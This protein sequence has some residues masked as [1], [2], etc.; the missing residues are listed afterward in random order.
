MKLKIV[1]FDAIEVRVVFGGSGG[2]A[3]F[4]VNFIIGEV[5]LLSLW[6]HGEPRAGPMLR[7]SL[8][9][10]AVCEAWYIIVARP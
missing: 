7:V 5:W 8:T 4:E 9:I 6:S 1:L 10:L 2:I 3:P